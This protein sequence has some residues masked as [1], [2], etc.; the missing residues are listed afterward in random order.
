[1]RHCSCI[2]NDSLSCLSELTSLEELMLD[3]CDSITDEGTLV[4]SLYTKGCHPSTSAARL[5]VG[6]MLSLL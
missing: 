3:A 6:A 2:A 4:S 5:L 1:M